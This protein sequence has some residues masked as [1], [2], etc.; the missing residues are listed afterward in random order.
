[1]IT[2]AITGLSHYLPDYVLT[3]DE[4]A[5]MVDT[6]DEWITTRTGIKSRRVLKDEHAGSSQLAIPAVR[7]VLE[8]TGTAPEKVECLICATSSPDY[9]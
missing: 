1:M 8:K 2:A 6:N 7:D 4:I 3:N 9:T 5:T